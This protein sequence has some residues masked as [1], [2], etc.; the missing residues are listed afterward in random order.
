[1]NKSKSTQR[2]AIK[3]TQETSS[4]EVYIDEEF[5]NQPQPRSQTTSTQPN[6]RR[7]FRDVSNIQPQ[8]NAVRPTTTTRL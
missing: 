7:A 1:M 3:P 4:F 8:R 2:S 5:R 6:A